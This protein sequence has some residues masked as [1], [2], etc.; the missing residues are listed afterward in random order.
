M[1]HLTRSMCVLAL[2]AISLAAQ[3]I[4]VDTVRTTPMVGIAFGQTARLNLLNPGPVSTAVGVVCTAA[5]TYFDASGAVL[6]SASV[7]VAPGTSM[8]VDLHSD[9]DLSLA[10][11]ARREIRATIAMPAVPPPAASSTST[12]TN[13]PPACKLVHSLE[14]FDSITGR[15]QTIVTKA[16]AIE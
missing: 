3:T 1:F 12:A 15:T 11:N 16:V 4:P 7:A 13:I 8:P 2:G 5:V 14:I 6:K 10:A 9:T